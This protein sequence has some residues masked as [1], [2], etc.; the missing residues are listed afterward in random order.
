MRNNELRVGRFTSSEIYKL[1]RLHTSNKSLAL[2]YIEE[3]RIE[4]RLG[5]TIESASYSQPMAWGKFMELVVFNRLGTDY[6]TATQETVEHPEF[7]GIWAGSLDFKDRKETFI[8]ELKCYQLKNFAKYTDCLLKQDISLLK[9]DFEKEYW[10]IVSNSDIHGTDLGE[11]I[12]FA[13]YEKDMDF[14]RDLAENY[15]A[16]DQ[17]QYRF[18]AEK[19]NWDLPCIKDDG[20]YKDL[21]KFRF[22]VP[23]EDKELL[24]ETVIKANKILLDG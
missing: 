4:R 5:K 16:P 7:K 15:D 6:K 22:E 18:I 10:Q 19:P 14:I 21:N 12:T 11:G 8:A 23:K 17:W 3:K 20:Y 1:M 9:K 2:T 24:R 13:P